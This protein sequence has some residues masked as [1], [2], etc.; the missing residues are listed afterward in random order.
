M[1]IKDYFGRLFGEAADRVGQR[2]ESTPQSSGVL[3]LPE[4]PNTPRCP[5]VSIP[6]L[7]A[8]IAELEK[9]LE[10]LGEGSADAPMLHMLLR[11]RRHVVARARAGKFLLDRTSSGKK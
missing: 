9:R 10:T 3:V 1:A 5:E 4:E 6:Q 11:N 8:D 7:E 2:S